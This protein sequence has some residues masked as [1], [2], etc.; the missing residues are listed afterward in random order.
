[1]Y[2]TL[3]PGYSVRNERYCSFLIR[4][5]G[6]LNRNT[7]DFGAFPIPPY[8]GYILEEVG[9][10]E[11]SDSLR[12]ISNEL[13]V[14]ETSVDNFVRQLTDGADHKRFNVSGGI[15]FILPADLL[16][17]STAPI[18]FSSYRADDF[19]PNEEFKQ[20]RP[21]APLSI[22]LMITNNC[23]TDCVYCYANRKLVPTLS[24][25]E[26]IKTIDE[27]KDD[28]VV[29]V[30]LTGGDVFA[31][32]DWEIVLRKVKEAG[33]RPFLST[34]PPL[35]K[36]QLETLRGLGYD[37]LQFSLDSS[38]STILTELINVGPGYIEEVKNMFSLC[39][40]MGI[41]VLVRSVLTNRNSSPK[42]IKNTY[43]FLASFDCIKEWDITPAFFS[44]YKREQYKEY[45]VSN[46]ALAHVYKFSKHDNLKFKIS[47]NKIGEQGYKLKKST[48]VENFVCENQICLANTT[49]LSILSNGTCSICEMLYDHEEFALGNV[50]ENS[51]KEIWN[52]QKALSLY[53]ATQVI[54]TPA[55]PCSKCSVV[56]GCRK[57]FGKR[58]C[59]LDIVK[60]G[61]GTADPDPRCPK[62]KDYTIIL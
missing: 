16:T 17:Q 37:E 6:I 32:Y 28:G 52:S 55:S 23:S 10:H 22:N 41:D 47:L 48:T 62:A 27:M 15:S 45:E 35:A 51:I 19:N 3:T 59:F 40:E 36:A 54:E 24:T 56:N 53:N 5:N 21:S 9:K 26:L 12:I 43:E 33:Y 58:I 11:L 29:N 39:T 8:I 31:R 2:V 14:S 1:M 49:G 25:E 42:D 46:D 50:R 34:K 61:G 20:H 13:E 60:T 7:Q 18:C 44:E 38:D 30:T 4:V 57:G